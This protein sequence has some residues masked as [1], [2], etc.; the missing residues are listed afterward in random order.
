MAWHDL[1]WEPVAFCEFDKFPSQVLAHHYPDVPN[2][3]DVTQITDEQIKA[4]GRIDLVVGGSPCQDLSVAGKRAGLAGERSGLFHE[5][6]R[7]F[8]AARSLCNAR[9]LLWENVPGAYSSHAG[10]DFAEVVGQ[11]AG[12]RFGVPS[13]KWQ[14]AGAAVGRHGLVEWRCLDAQ[15]VRVESFAGAVP[16]R[17]RRVFALLDTGDWASRHPVLLEPEGLQGHPPPRREKGEGATGILEVGARTGSS[18]NDPRAG[19][20]I[21]QPG[22]P[23]FTLQAGKQHGVAHTLLTPNGGRAGMGVD[24]LMTSQPTAM[25]FDLVQITSKVNRSRVGPDLPASTLSAHSQMHVAHTL[26]AEGFDA[27]KDGTGRGTPLVPEVAN[28]LTQRMHKGI[29]TT[30]DEGQT[31]IPVAI[32]NATRGKDQNGLGLNSDGAMYT[33]DQ[34]SQHGVAQPVA[35]PIN[36][37]MQVR[38]LT[39][40]ECESLQGFPRGFT[41][42]PWRGK[43]AEKCPDG[44]R[45]KALGNSMA[46]NVM[47]WIGRRI[48]GVS[49]D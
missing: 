27:S 1:G 41:K 2:L 34:G 38:R 10:R 43:P 15:Y 8:H 3:G 31:A 29:N 9:W 45:Y 13:R 36:T 26:K 7:I 32:Q 37:P 4:L 40:E 44:P 17:R 20:G 35:L 47:A 23:M 11:M 21:S 33:L 19:V 28:P 16:Q 18:T 49:N 12:A 30:C 39:V 14:T 48:Q 24:A 42:I 22:D 5:Q 6:L 25:A 46:V